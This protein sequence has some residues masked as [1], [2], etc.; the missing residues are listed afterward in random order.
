MAGLVFDK[1]LVPSDFSKHAHGAVDYALELVP[2]AKCLTVLHVVPPMNTFSVGD[3]AIAW[4]TVSDETRQVNLYQTFREHFK[5]PKYDG[6]R[7]EVAFGS[8]ADEITRFAQDHLCDLILLPSQSS[9]PG[10]IAYDFGRKSQRIL[11][12]RPRFG[13]FK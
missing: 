12:K 6:I 8:P 2:E 4:H 11:P 13:T 3:P 7:F 10:I 1:V 9:S 5:E